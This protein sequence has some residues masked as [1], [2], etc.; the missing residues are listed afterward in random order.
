MIVTVFELFE[1]SV[2]SLT[3]AY[4]C[5]TYA[6][7]ICSGRPAVHVFCLQLCA[8]LLCRIP[9]VVRDSDV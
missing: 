9:K 2:M 5:V 7:H 3:L 1:Y 4:F 8:G 6:V